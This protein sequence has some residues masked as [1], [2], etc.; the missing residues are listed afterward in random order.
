MLKPMTDEQ[1]SNV[2]AALAVHLA[3]R[4]RL[5]TDEV[6]EH[7]YAAPAALVVILQHPGETIDFLSRVLTLTHSG[8]VRLVER[9]VEGGL[10]GKTQGADARS[11][12]L[13]CTPLGT[14]RA[15]A[16]LE[17]RKRVVE[18]LITALTRD[19]KRSFEAILRKLPWNGVTTKPEGVHTCRLCDI[20]TCYLRGNC[21]VTVARLSSANT[22][23]QRAT[24]KIAEEGYDPANPDQV[25]SQRAR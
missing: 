10:V 20:N 1:M 17:A 13:A 8:T 9:L 5:S 4:I 22:A 11:L 6:A 19:E 23:S 15:K 21:P 3:D 16:I 25:H 2:L 18:P 14:K 24:R 7:G 12:A